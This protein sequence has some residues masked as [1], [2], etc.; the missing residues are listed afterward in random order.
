MNVIWGFYSD[1][2]TSDG[3]FAAICQQFVVKGAV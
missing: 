1:V 2:N 3:D